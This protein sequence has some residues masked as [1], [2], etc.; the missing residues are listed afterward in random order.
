[1]KASLINDKLYSLVPFGTLAHGVQG[2]G[3]HFIWKSCVSVRFEQL[4]FIIETYFFY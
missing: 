1:M 2:D 3:G 4:G